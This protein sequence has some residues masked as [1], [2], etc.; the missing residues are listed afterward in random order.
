MS[1]LDPD[2]VHVGDWLRFL[3]QLDHMDG[4]SLAAFTADQLINQIKYEFRKLGEDAPEYF[5]HMSSDTHPVFN[6]C[7][8]IFGA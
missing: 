3:K 5:I 7:P 8:V 1:S 2:R 6:V 4:P